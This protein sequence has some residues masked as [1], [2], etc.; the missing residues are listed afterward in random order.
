MANFIDEFSFK[1]PDNKDHGKSKR[2]KPLSS[3]DPHF[4]TGMFRFF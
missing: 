1:H 4:S 2:L 3:S